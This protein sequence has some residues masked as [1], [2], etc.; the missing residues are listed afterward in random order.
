MSIDIRIPTI[1]RPYTKDQKSVQAEKDKAA[2]AHE[3]TLTSLNTQITTVTDTVSRL[4]SLTRMLRNTVA[5]MSI[6]SQY[7]TARSEAQA[8]IATALAIAK[9]SGVMPT[10]ESLQNALSNSVLKIT[11]VRIR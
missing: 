2:K 8:Q 11:F 5:G 1:L 3:A 4:T 7:G 6:A 9:A 10:E